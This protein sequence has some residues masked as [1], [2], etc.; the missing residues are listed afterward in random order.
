MFLAFS[1]AGKGIAGMAAFLNIAIHMRPY[2]KMPIIIGTWTIIRDLSNMFFVVILIVMAF[3]TIFNY[4]KYKF[5]GDLI[6]RLIVAAVLINFSL[7]LGGIVIDITQGFN[8]IF[9]NAIGDV[10]NRLGAAL[11]PAGSLLPTLKDSDL[12]A[13]A[14]TDL[15]GQ[16]I[17]SLL[18]A[19]ILEVIVLFGLVVATIFAFLRI[20]ILWLLLILSP[21]AF[22]A[23]ILPESRS[24]WDRWLKFFIGWNLYLPVYL[25]F[26]YLGLM[27]LSAKPQVDA[28]V[29]QAVGTGAAN[30]AFGDGLLNSFT[31]TTVAFY[32]FVAWILTH[33][34][35]GAINI[36][37]S[38]GKGADWGLKKATGW[39]NGIWGISHYR[40][41]EKALEDRRK[42]FGKE[43][44]QNRFLNKIYG[45]TESREMREAKFKSAFG[46]RGAEF[47]DQKDFIG[48]V[49]REVKRYLE[50]EKA[51]RLVVDENFK[52]EAYASDRKS[53]KG[54]AMRAIL[55]ERGMIEGA[56]F[57]KDMEEWTNNPFLAKSMSDR[58]KK[59]KYKNVSPDQLLRMATAE[60][61][62]ENLKKPGAI[63]ARK[64]WLN[65]IKGNDKALEMMTLSQFESSLSLMGGP[66]T[67]DAQDLRE[68]LAK[69]RIDL[70]ID[71][72]I[73]KKREKGEVVGPYTRA[74]TLYKAM[75]KMTARDI[76]KMSSKIFED[77]DFQRAVAY[78]IRKTQE[79]DPAYRKGQVIKDS[80]GKEII[81][82]DGK[83]VRQ[84]K[85]YSGGGSNLK[86][87]LKEAVRGDKKKLKILR[88]KIALDIAEGRAFHEE[89]EKEKKEE[90]KE[91]KEEKPTE[92][93]SEK[94]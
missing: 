93:K 44:F 69:K 21:L 1:L 77:K 28:A 53:A 4:G 46:V 82:P 39:A 6:F 20:P 57:S 61:P 23:R 80:D 64:E 41:A 45:G 13:T 2:P 49:D 52:K 60:P 10:G 47:K 79:D 74:A 85:D 17:I 9:L 40:G 55:Y 50:Y 86:A 30:Q 35:V 51:G 31:F 75:E 94:K 33:G 48:K 5:S 59:G 71:Y 42:Q 19:F 67:K 65:N 36:A 73:K 72:D 83:P 11:D 43:G 91:E 88:E 12:T 32:F 37:M 78:R 7:I 14:V 90:K 54:I 22:M 26:L 62:F 16:S 76:G 25:F 29:V 68:A 27:F 34:S 87:T 81:G 56:E 15:V 92:D 70:V 8:A 38:F 24:Q 63:A 58:A 89:A 18:F 66:Q 3:A 84:R